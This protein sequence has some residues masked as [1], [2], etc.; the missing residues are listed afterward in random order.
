MT[1]DRRDNPWWIRFQPIAEPRAR[2][3]CF[4]F[5]GGSAGLFRTWAGRFPHVEVHALQLPGREN[6]LREPPLRRLHEAIEPLTEALAA[7]LDRPFALFGYSLGGLLAF[8]TLRRLRR[9]GSPMPA[10]LL[11]AAA[12]APAC[13]HARTPPVHLLS[14]DDFVAELRRFKGTPEIV[15]RT[16]E[17]LQALLPMLRADFEMLE[18]YAVADEPALNVPVTAYGGT[19]DEEVSPDKLAAWSD[20]TTGSFSM[21]FFSGDHFFL[22]TS[23]ESLLAAVAG[24]LESIR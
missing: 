9:T 15:L 16:P 8:E 2:L 1:S 19:V 13:E 7:W 11:I 14:D 24:E 5:A 10:R 23:S 6:R 4:P 3:F 12:E 17:L 20:A 21:Q 18:T 22:K